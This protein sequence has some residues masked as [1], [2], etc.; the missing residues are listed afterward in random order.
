M[1]VKAK[2]KKNFFFKKPELPPHSGVLLL[3][4][5]LCYSVYML[6]SYIYIYM[7]ILCY[8]V[9]MYIYI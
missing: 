6:F 8:V 1:N 3:Y 4:I 9:C 2:L 7:Y 5:V